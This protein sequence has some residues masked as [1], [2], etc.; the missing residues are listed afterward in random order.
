MVYNFEFKIFFW[1]WMED[2]LWNPQGI[3]CFLS[4]ELLF[5]SSTLWGSEFI[6]SF[7]IHYYIL[8]YYTS[9]TYSYTCT[10]WQLVISLVD[11]YVVNQSSFLISWLQF[12]CREFRESIL[13]VMPHQWV[14]MLFYLFTSNY[15]SYFFITS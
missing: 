11:V 7:V 10:I 9:Y 3:S 2:V 4:S 8:K 12:E 14:S 5:C 13:G 6:F 1:G 15:Y